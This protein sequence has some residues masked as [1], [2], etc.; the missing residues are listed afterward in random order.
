[1]IG[2]TGGRRAG[3]QAAVGGKKRVEGLG[4]SSPKYRNTVLVASDSLSE[5]TRAGA[6]Q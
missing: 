1:M 4:R 5:L 6:R 2:E 3:R